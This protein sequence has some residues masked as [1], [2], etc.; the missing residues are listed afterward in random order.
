MEHDTALKLFEKM[1]QHG[2]APNL[3]TYNA[4]ITGLCRERRLEEAWRLVDHSKQC[5]ISPSEDIYN[6]LVECCCNKRMYEEAVDLID[7]MLKHGFLPHLECFKR[8]VC[9]LYDDGND[10]KAKATFYRL[11]HCGYN[12]D[13]VAW[14]VLI[15]GLLQRGFVNGC[16]ELVN[17]MEKSGCTIDPQ[18]HA[19][20]I[21]GIL[22]Q[23]EGTYT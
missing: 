12:Y 4:L 8:L 22:S 17:V 23:R 10:E 3:N 14:K 11:L 18:T 13:E 15:D 16:S 5:G 6:K 19:M 20:L 1:K 7:V 9:G 2:C 21:Q